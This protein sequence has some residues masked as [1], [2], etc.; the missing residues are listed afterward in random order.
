MMAYMSLFQPPLTPQPLHIL[1]GR[2][3]YIVGSY[4]FTVNIYAVSI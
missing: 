2:F 4:P 1:V 3:R